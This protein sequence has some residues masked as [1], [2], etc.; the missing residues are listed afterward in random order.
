MNEK[1]DPQKIDEP[2]REIS[3]EEVEIELQQRLDV[4]K[5]QKKHKLQK[6]AVWLLVMLIVAFGP[7][8]V[9][10]TINTEKVDSLEL[11]PEPKQVA[12]S[13][14]TTISRFGLEATLEYVATYELAGRVV[15]TFDYYPLVS[16]QDKLSPTEFR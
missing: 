13:G 6:R 8:L 3:R 5:K 7:R 15:G 14:S 10:K 1:I 2:F 16:N 9:L 11:I 12:T 4:H